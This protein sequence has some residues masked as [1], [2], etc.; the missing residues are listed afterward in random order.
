MPL[1][2]SFIHSFKSGKI[3]LASVVS[4]KKGNLKGSP[5]IQEPSRRRNTLQ[6][7]HGVTRKYHSQKKKFTILKIGMVERS[8]ALT[9]L[10]HYH[11]HLQGCVCYP[12]SIYTLSHPSTE[13]R[14]PYWRNPSPLLLYVFSCMRLSIQ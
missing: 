14:V 5:G 6:I 9:P 1:R 4:W 12:Q 8:Y 13:I 10:P 7:H 3:Y 11:L 2:S